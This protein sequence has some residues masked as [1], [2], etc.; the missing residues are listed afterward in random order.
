MM[1]TRSL[2]KAALEV[3][4]GVFPPLAVV[5]DPPQIRFSWSVSQDME[6]RNDCMPGRAFVLGKRAG[7]CLGLLL[8]VWAVSGQTATRAQSVNHL[9]SKPAASV[10]DID[11]TEAVKPAQLLAAPLGERATAET[12]AGE[13]RREEPPAEAGAAGASQSQFRVERLSL[14]GGAELLTIFG[15]AEGLRASGR[16]APEVPLISVVRDTLGDNDP[17]NDRL[18]YVWMLTYTEPT[19]LKRFAAAVPFLYGHIGNQTRA[20]SRPPAPL[21]DLANAAR[22]PWKTIFRLGVQDIVLDNFGIPL[23][24][25]TRSYPR[26]PSDYHH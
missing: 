9:T 20:S 8:L 14:A 25:P 24:P 10:P 13:A 4:P 7:R 2:K 21:I 11:R 3:V 1:R 16:P 15:R 6:N 18:R 19:L 17:E 12:L 23:R 26:N 22:Q 5:S